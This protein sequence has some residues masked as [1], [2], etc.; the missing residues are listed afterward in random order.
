MND[1]KSRRKAARLTL[2]D[3]STATGIRFT[4]YAAIESGYG[5]ATEAEKQ[6]IEKVLKTAAEEM[7]VFRGCFG[8]Q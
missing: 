7:A 6:A 4:R 8:R 2:R 3:M 5:E 1:F